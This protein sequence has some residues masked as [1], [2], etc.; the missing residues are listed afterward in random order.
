MADYGV[1]LTTTDGR[2]FITPSS[3]PVSLLTKATASGSGKVSV[4]V[5]IDASL[6]NLPFVL[7]DAP[8]FPSYSIA[9]NVMTITCHRTSD[10]GGTINMQAYVFSIKAPVPPKWGIALWNAQGRCILTNETRVLRDIRT[11]GTKGAPA[12]SGTSINQTITGKWAIM[13]E[14]AG[15]LSGVV[16]QGPFS[17]VQP[18]FAQYNGT[19]TIISSILAS[20]IPVG[21]QGSL[22]STQN[23]VKAIDASLY[24]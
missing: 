6:I 18:F 23:S 4:S 8:A 21:G 15:Q 1:Y 22:T 9:G 14:L 12:S 2:P 13:P 17:I 24:D 10:T 16:N 5:N 20:N 7:S 11:F 19:S 3:I